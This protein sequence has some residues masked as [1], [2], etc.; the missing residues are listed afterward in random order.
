MIIKQSKLAEADKFIR[1]LTY[2]HG[3]IDA[4]A[5]GSRRLTSRKSPHLDQLN[6]IKFQLARGKSPQYLIQVETIESFSR[7]KDNFKLTRTCFYLL[8]ILNLILPSF[9]PDP[10][11][12]SSFKN[13]LLAL[14]QESASNRKLNI[15]FQLYLINHLG[16]PP[17]PGSRPD[18]LI[19]YFESLLD[20]RL[21]STRIKMG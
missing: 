11:L 5:K 14:N 21:S 4:I 9:Q 8:E 13:Y 3:L 19:E 18:Q 20:R 12:F 7:I 15:D 6:L 1:I 10:T 17:P 2:Q 16:F